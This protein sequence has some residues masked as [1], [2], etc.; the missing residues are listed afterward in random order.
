MCKEVMAMKK[1]GV[2]IIFAVFIL[3]NATPA[4][5]EYSTIFNNSGVAL[6]A[7]GGLVLLGMIGNRRFLKR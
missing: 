1:I 7:G 3:I 4:L 6:V 5:A 2:L